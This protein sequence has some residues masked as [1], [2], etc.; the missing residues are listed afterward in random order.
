MS[1]RTKLITGN[2]KLHRTVRES[3]E[4]ARTV[5]HRLD[6]GAKAEV[7]VAPVFTAIHAVHE[8]LGENARVLLA[9][10]DVFWEDQG[11]FTGEVSAPLLKDAGCAYVIVGHSERRQ[12]FHDTDDAVRRKVGA[13]LSHGLAPIVCVGETLEQRE[14]DRTEAVVLGQL[15][16]AVQALSTL[17][18][19]VIAYEPVWAIGTGRTAKASD[20]QAVHASIRVRLADRFGSGQADRARILYGGSVKPSNAAELLAQPDI[21][22]ALVGG[23]SLEADSFM[24]I[25]QAAG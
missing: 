21:D 11:A 7:V 2:W 1:A 23:A 19:V 20:A 10:Q 13:A 14:A 15:D 8:A 18:R 3:V 16:A 24:T 25:V 6:R 4:L 22:G 12:Y 5:L 17:D 9:A